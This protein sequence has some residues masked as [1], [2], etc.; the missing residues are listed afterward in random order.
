MH[1]P[2]LQMQDRHLRE[3]TTVD[4]D[5]IDKRSLT[6]S[7]SSLSANAGVSVATHNLQFSYVG[8]TVTAHSEALPFFKTEKRRE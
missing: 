5:A 1:R 3:P 4:E 8:G 6:S 7:P 2:I